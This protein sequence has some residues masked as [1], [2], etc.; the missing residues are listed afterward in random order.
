M[1]YVRTS[2]ICLLLIY[3]VSAAGCHC[4]D[5]NA[6]VRGSELSILALQAFLVRGD[7]SEGI[8]RLR[9]GWECETSMVLAS[10]GGQAQQRRSK[11]PKASDIDA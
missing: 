8:G 5:F 11:E 10:D 9:R 1:P 7:A 2:T 4:F 3:F 6:M